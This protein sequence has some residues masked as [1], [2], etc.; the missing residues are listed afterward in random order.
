MSDSDLMKRLRSTLPVCPYDQRS[1][2]YYTTP[3]DKPCV[4]CGG[5]PDGPDKCRGADTRC[6]AEAANRIEA[7]AARVAKLEE[8]LNHL[9]HAF[10]NAGNPGC[11]IAEGPFADYA[12]NL[13]RAALGEAS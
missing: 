3:N 9:E 1:P 2:D 8:A 12:L 11:D 5:E 7:L 4:V 10:S 13:I 6:M